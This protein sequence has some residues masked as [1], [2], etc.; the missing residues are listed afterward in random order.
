MKP[1]TAF[2]LLLVLASPAA[3]AQ[4]SQPR[5]ETG[6]LESTDPDRKA[7]LPVSGVRPAEYTADRAW[8]V[9]IHLHGGGQKAPTGSNTRCGSPS[10]S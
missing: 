7:H 3:L 8:P 1:A 5:V 9:V 6:F 10:K 2:A 4:P